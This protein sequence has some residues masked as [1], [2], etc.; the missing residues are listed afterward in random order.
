MM[1]PFVECNLLSI[2]HVTVV[3]PNASNYVSFL[4]ISKYSS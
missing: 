1:V 4:R 3:V 2:L